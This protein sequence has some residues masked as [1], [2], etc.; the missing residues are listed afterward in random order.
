[1]EQTAITIALTCESLREREGWGCGDSVLP[2]VAFAELVEDVVEA[3]DMLVVLVV[4]V[5]C[6]GTLVIS[7]N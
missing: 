2:G 5:D 1:M 4:T 6:E 3:L 7:K